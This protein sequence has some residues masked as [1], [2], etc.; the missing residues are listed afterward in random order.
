MTSLHAAYAATQLLGIAALTAG[1][2]LLFGLP[3]ALTIGGFAVLLGS[4]I[5][6]ALPPGS[7]DD[8]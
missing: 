7:V 3:W 6:H 5:A 8:P 2:L 1:V 4:S